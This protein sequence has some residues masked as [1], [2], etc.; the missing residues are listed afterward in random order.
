M[1][2][3]T[4][5]W[6]MSWVRKWVTSERE[7]LRQY[8]WW[9]DNNVMASQTLIIRQKH[10]GVIN[11]FI[12]VVRSQGRRCC[13]VGSAMSDDARRWW[14]Y[15]QSRTSQTRFRCDVLENWRLFTTNTSSWPSRQTTER[16]GKVV[17][18]MATACCSGILL[19]N[20]PRCSEMTLLLS[21]MTTPKTLHTS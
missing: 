17:R 12:Q 10:T 1:K 8:E 6:W 4:Q 13:H 20:V 9:K 15:E 14:L 18:R 19:V 2:L 21:G 11:N 3:V 5:C 7:R 16:L